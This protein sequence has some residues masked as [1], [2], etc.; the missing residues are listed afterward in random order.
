L[1]YIHH[2]NR[3]GI[4]WSGVGDGVGKRCRLGRAIGSNHIHAVDTI[5]ASGNDTFACDHE[6]PFGTDVFCRGDHGQTIWTGIVEVGEL[7]PL[8]ELVPL[9]D[10][11]SETLGIVIGSNEDGTLPSERLEESFVKQPARDTMTGKFQPQPE[12]FGTS[13]NRTF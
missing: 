9:H 7:V 8:L 2:V 13:A 1:G 6:P 10:P 4:E 5:L 12:L 11:A 3:V